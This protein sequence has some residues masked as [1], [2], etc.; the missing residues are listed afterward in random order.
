MHAFYCVGGEWKNSKE[1]F[2][3]GIGGGFT[4]IEM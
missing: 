4:L 3:Y 2:V 1:E